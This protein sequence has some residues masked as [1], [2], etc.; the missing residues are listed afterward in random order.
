MKSSIAGLVRTDRFPFLASGLDLYQSLDMT[1][2]VR[3][4]DNCPLA[5]VR[6][7]LG[8]SHAASLSLTDELSAVELAVSIPS[9][10]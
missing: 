3:R 9:S 1:I 10:S 6:L 7:S 2:H 8:P 4:A 5:L